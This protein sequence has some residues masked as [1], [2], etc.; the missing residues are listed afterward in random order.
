MKLHQ[1]M[2]MVPGDSEATE[3][4]V[5][6][7]ADG[8]HD[9]DDDYQMVQFNTGSPDS[10]KRAKTVKV[11]LNRKRKNGGRIND[12]DAQEMKKS[13][14][15]KDAEKKSKKVES[16]GKKG[17]GR[18]KSLQGKTSAAKDSAEE[19][20]SQ[21]AKYSLTSLIEALR[22]SIEKDKGQ[23]GQKVMNKDNLLG[24]ND[25][26]E[27]EEGVDYSGIIIDSEQEIT[28]PDDIQVQVSTFEIDGKTM[29]R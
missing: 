28:L 22:D 25:D 1:D 9:D 2:L 16:S 7:H 29:F 21:K 10:Q 5:E 27:E 4:E 17:K 26:D 12:V 18:G 24:D 14:K 23:K 3:G 13:R 8:D 11:L 15:S 19:S 6:G 20:D